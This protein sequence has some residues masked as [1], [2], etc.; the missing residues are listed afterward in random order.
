VTVTASSHADPTA[1]DTAIFHV[2]VRAHMSLP[3]IWNGGG[4]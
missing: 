3:L 1:S 2:R 4:L